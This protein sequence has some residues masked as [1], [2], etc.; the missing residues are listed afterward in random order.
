MNIT[1][2]FGYFVK[3]GKKI[4][5]YELAI[6]EHPNPTGCSFIEVQDK[7]TLDTVILDNTDIDKEFENSVKIQENRNAFIDALMTGDVATQEEIKGQQE[8]LLAQKV[9]E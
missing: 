3:N 6:G 7:A 2:G 1:T 5:K 8:T 9:K 4:S